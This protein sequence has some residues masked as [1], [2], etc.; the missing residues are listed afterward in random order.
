MVHLEA[1]RLLAAER[2]TIDVSQGRPRHAC[3]GRPQPLEHLD[4]HEL[5][6]DGGLLHEPEGCQS[7]GDKGLDDDRRLDDRRLGEG[8]T[9]RKA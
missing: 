2:S 4:A 6:D 9:L 1:R 5:L 3:A 8:R 7:A